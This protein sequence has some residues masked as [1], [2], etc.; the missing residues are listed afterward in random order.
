MPTILL[1]QK[2]GG[3][4]TILSAS[5]NAMPTTLWV[6]SHCQQDLLYGSVSFALDDLKKQELS[7]P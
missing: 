2:V 6:D 3:S 4:P 7:S 5:G 1:T